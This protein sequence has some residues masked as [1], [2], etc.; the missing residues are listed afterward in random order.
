MNPIAKDETGQYIS[1]AWPGGYP[2]FHLAADG[3]PLCATCCNEN[4]KQIDAAE[5]YLDPDWQIVASDI[6]WEDEHMYCAHCN[7]QIE[8]AY[9]EP[10]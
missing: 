2:I 8:S 9:G 3:E 4:A 7:K 1:Y 5:E 10:A 6:N